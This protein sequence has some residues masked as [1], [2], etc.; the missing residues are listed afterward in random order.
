MSR[1]KLFLGLGL[2]LMLAIL[3]AQSFSQDGPP[4]GRGRRGGQGG[5]GGGGQ[6]NRPREEMRGQRDPEQMRQMMQQRMMQRVKQNLNATDEQWHQIE[7]PLNKVM[8]LSRQSEGMGGGMYG[9][10][11]AARGQ[12]PGRAEGA[13][14]MP[15]PESKIEKA[16]MELREALNNGEK[17]TIEKKLEAFRTARA[18]A[19]KDLDAARK[20]LK[21]AVTLAQEAEL[22]LMGYLE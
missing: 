10:A 16:R 4:E 6:M 12:R 11:M 19:Q 17:E 18:E 5:Q 13:P 8:T 7:P 2:L 9:R 22:V 21:K 14:D 20:E 3:A 15:E 1:N